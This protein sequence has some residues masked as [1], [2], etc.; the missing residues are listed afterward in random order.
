MVFEENIGSMYMSSQLYDV[1]IN[2]CTENTLKTTSISELSKILQEVFPQ[3][4]LETI[5]EYGHYETGNSVRGL[6]TEAAEKQYI[7]DDL[8]FRVNDNEVKSKEIG[9]IVVIIF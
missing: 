2:H 8:Q 6:Q 7:I 5:H 4:L 9:K 1:F 3:T